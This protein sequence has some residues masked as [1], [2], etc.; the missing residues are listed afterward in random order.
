MKTRN[1]KKKEVWKPINYKSR[2]RGKCN[3]QKV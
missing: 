3:K 1:R 2:R